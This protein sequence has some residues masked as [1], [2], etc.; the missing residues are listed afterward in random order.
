MPQNVKVSFIHYP[1]SNL[2]GKIKT[3]HLNLFSWKDIALDKAYT[4]GRRG[5]WRDYVDLYFIIKQGLPLPEIIERSKK[6]FGDSFSE[7]LFL[8]QLIYFKD[9]EDFTIEF[10]ED[11]LPYGD[12]KS[13]LKK[14]LRN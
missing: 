9:I 10:I 1:Y 3:P 14:K 2:Y 11:N 8:S 7:K 4:I 12:I 13:F 6:K 5:E